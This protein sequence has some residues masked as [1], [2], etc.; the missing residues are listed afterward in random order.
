MQTKREV[1]E[2]RKERKK[3]IRIFFTI[4]MTLIVAGVVH[5]RVFGHPEYMI[6]WHIPGAVFLVLTCWHYS[7]LDEDDEDEEE[8]K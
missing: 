5:K 4:F 7:K 6:Y 1:R 3:L 2:R 8:E